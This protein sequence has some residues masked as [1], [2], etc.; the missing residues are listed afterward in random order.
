MCLCYI[1]TVTSNYIVCALNGTTSVNVL[2][3]PLMSFECSEFI[4]LIDDHK[5]T[6]GKHTFYVEKRAPKSNL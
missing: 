5:I 3:D 4:I 1:S 2:K 6:A